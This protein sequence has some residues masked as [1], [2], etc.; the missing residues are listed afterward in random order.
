MNRWV[1][2]I[3]ALGMAACNKPTMSDQIKGVWQMDSVL[4]GPLNV[5]DDSIQFII[6]FKDSVAIDHTGNRNKRVNWIVTDSNIIIIP[7]PNPIDTEKFTVVRLDE[8]RM[9]LKDTPGAHMIYLRRLETWN[10]VENDSSS[11]TAT[12]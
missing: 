10:P 12:N 4:D 9:I 8:E 6:E 7:N 5:L 3:I 11:K 2:M 1:L